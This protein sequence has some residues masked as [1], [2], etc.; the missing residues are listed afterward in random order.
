MTI[1]IHQPELEALIQQRMA[2]GAFRDVDELLF[3]AIGALNESLPPSTNAKADNLVELFE[4][5]RGLLTN[6]EVD[7]LFRRDRSLARP[8]DLS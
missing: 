8:L 7:T 1:E 3:K 2:S 5:V 4:P 6:E